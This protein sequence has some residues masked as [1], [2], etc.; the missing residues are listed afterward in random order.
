MIWF[1]LLGVAVMAFGVWRRLGWRKRAADYVNWPSVEATILSSG[2]KTRET[3]DDDNN[4]IDMW[5]P[6]VRYR[7]VVDGKE[8]E[9][10][11]ARWF[12][13]NFDARGAAERWLADHLEGRRVRAFYDPAKPAASALELNQPRDA[14]GNG[15]IWVGGA[16]IIGALIVGTP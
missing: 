11:K 6:L 8:F 15:L 14:P 16:L 1:V 10:R 13:F 3:L 5:E 7:Y 2:L 4:Q 12:E 9:G